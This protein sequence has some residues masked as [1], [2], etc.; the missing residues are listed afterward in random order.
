M[1]FLSF[2]WLI[3]AIPPSSIS[4]HFDSGPERPLPGKTKNARQQNFSAAGD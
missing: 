3:M 4:L 2:S 1:T